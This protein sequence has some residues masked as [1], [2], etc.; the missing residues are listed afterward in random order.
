MYAE[1][2]QPL[3]GSLNGQPL[4]GSL[5]VQLRMIIAYTILNGRL[6]VHYYRRKLLH[7]GGNGSIVIIRY[8]FYA[9]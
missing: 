8:Q 1:E 5:N 4:N 2:C 9:S 3:N 7:I 6:F